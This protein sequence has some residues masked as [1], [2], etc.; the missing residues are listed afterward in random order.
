MEKTIETRVCCIHVWK[1]VAPVASIVSMY[2][3]IH[4]LVSSPPEQDAAVC[5]WP[6]CEA[7]QLR[8][9]YAHQTTN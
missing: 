1:S 9:G 8:L 6:V 3:R 2:P 5:Y 4:L 7:I